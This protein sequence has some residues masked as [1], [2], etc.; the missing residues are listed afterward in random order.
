MREHDQQVSSFIYKPTISPQIPGQFSEAT[1]DETVPALTKLQFPAKSPNHRT[2]AVNTI[3][4]AQ[5]S[6]FSA[7]SGPVGRV[8]DWT[9]GGLGMTVSAAFET[10]VTEVDFHHLPVCQPVT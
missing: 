3:A 1:P 4:P 2:T 6:A 7:H 5:Q 8:R 10:W 9:A